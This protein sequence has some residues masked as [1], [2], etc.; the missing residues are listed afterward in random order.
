MSRSTIS[1]ESLAQSVADSLGSS[2]S[3]AV[4]P[5]TASV[6]D[7]EFDPFEDLESQVASDADSVEPSVASELFVDHVSPAIS[8]ALDPDGDQPLGS[9]D[10]ADYYGGF[11]FIEDNPSKDEPPV[12][13]LFRTFSLGTH[14][15]QMPRKSV[16]PQS[17]LLSSTLALIA[18]FKIGESS[19]ATAAR[20]HGLLWPKS[21]SC[22]RHEALGFTM[23]EIKALQHQ[24][25]E[26]DDRLTRFGER[27]ISPKRNSM[28]VAAIKRL[29]S[30]RVT[31]ALLTYEENQNS[32]NGN[33]NGNGNDNK[34]GND[35]R[36]GNDNG[37][38]SH[39]SG[40]GNQGLMVMAFLIFLAWI[41]GCCSVLCELALNKKREGK[42]RAMINSK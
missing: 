9:A 12:R 37:N 13:T 27:K 2:V 5:Y 15:V 10:T 8:A 22:V 21:R 32:R 29:I 3:S 4:L 35:N 7:L 11:E 40:S 39:D 23:D 17:I 25:Q 36:N 31:D 24:R 6:M 16:R 33:R 38:G 26:S 20:Q 34:N 42:H 14:T 1:Y 19:A 18:E 41:Q 28:S 30:Q